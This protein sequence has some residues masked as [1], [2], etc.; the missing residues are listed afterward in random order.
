[1]KLSCDY[2]GIVEALKRGTAHQVCP[3]SV[4]AGTAGDTAAEMGIY[5][6]SSVD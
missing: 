3:G 1:M 4:Q 5:P 6:G 2:Q